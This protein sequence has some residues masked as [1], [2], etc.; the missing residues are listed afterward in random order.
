MWLYHTVQA[1][2]KGPR[3]VI[4]SP[5]VVFPVCISKE[6]STKHW[7]VCGSGPL[8]HSV[9][10]VYSVEVV[11]ESP[12]LSLE[13]QPDR[14]HIVKKDIY[15]LYSKDNCTGKK[16][17]KFSL[18]CKRLSSYMASSEPNIESWQILCS[19]SKLRYHCRIHYHKNGCTVRYLL[20]H[21]PRSTKTMK[22][23]HP[24][25]DLATL[26]LT[27]DKSFSHLYVHLWVRIHVVKQ[28]LVIGILLIPLQRLVVAEVISQRDKKHLAAVEFGLFTVLIQEQVS[29]DWERGRERGGGRKNWGDTFLGIQTALLRMRQF[30]RK[31]L[32]KVEDQI[33]PGGIF[34]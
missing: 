12:K 27:A 21:T 17:K 20:Q 16:K 24:K 22:K 19:V 4:A 30:C 26:F 34:H 14:W 33:S 1:L 32:W 13:E 11:C 2:V 9:C 23:T 10:F 15:T 7:V 5:V 28:L 29:P 3:G 25:K 18:E 31:S 6:I 8:G